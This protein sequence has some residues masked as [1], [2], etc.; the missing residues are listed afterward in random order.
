MYASALFAYPWVV[1]LLAVPLALRWR[2]WE[3]IGVGLFMDFL[4][5]PTP[6]S[7]L[8]FE[9]L[10]LATLIACLLV[11]ALEPLRRQLLLGHALR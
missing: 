11:F 1:A 9:S 2:A 7:F 8:T 6:V 5:M 4:W 10:P 3:V